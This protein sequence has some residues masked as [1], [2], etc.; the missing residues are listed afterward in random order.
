MKCRE[1]SREGPNPRI[2][3]CLGRTKDGDIVAPVSV[4]PASHH[5]RLHL[6]HFSAHLT[7]ASSLVAVIL[8]SYYLFRYLLRRLGSFLFLFLF[9]FMFTLF[10]ITNRI[11]I[12]PFV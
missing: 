2:F 3:T 6:T 4:C 12:I 7:P 11:V 8:Q 9:M 10:V 1:T 5:W